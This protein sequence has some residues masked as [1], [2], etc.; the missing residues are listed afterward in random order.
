MVPTQTQNPNASFKGLSLALNKLR[1][2][3]WISNFTAALAHI[4][5][6]I[7]ILSKTEILSSEETILSIF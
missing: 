1:G 6:D 5:G 4:F 7:R 2:F 3:S